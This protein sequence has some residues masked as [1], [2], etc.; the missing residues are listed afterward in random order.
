[1]KDTRKKLTDIDEHV[2]ASNLLHWHSDG[3]GLRD[4]SDLISLKF[5]VMHSINF[6]KIIIQ[7]YKGTAKQKAAHLDKVL[8]DIEKFKIKI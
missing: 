7:N 1:M 2:I 8:A 4:V 5:H 6:A 3:T